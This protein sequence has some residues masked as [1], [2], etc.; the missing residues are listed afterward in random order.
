MIIS[1][2]SSLKTQVFFAITSVLFVAAMAFFSRNIIGYRDIALILLMVVSSLAMLLDIIPVLV[3]AILSALIWN[4]FF[5]P[6]LMTFHIGTT[7]DI[8]MFSLYFIIALLNAVLNFQ[9]RKFE[10]KARDRE[11]KEKSIK[12]YNAL[13]NSLSHELRTPISTIIGAVDTLKEDKD[14]L[15]VKNK[16]ELLNQIDI[17]TIRLNKQVENLLSMSRLETGLLK[18]NLQWCDVN[19]LIQMV[20]SKYKKANIHFKPNEDLP[21]CSIDSGL[22]EQCLINIIAN[23]IHYNI[24]NVMIKINA[25]FKDHFLIIE[26]QDNGTGIPKE[27]IDDIFN[28][29]YRL[30]NT[31]TG[32]TGLGLSIVKGF[33]EAHG[34]TIFAENI[35]P[36][37]L[38]ITQKIPV[39][40][41]YINHLRNE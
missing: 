31:K 3:S 19:E 10:Q 7:E 40:T 12:L 21:I 35:K 33:V 8:L 32:G 25:Y 28:K 36:H 38:K 23:S 4:F 2:K 6:P 34:G 14:R 15:S 27:N 5:I 16:N 24:E 17:A 22:M 1:R 26:I 20:V 30:P 39:K 41:S 18:L 13:L 37:G 29:F 11:D 9:I